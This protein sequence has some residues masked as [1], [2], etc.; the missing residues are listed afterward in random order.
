MGLFDV[1]FTEKAGSLVSVL[2]I[3]TAAR[4][5]VLE[6]VRAL[7]FDLRVQIVRVE[8]VVQETGL[9]ERFHIAEFDGA[10]IS[11]RRAAAIR[12]TVR[13]ALRARS[14]AEAAA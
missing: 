1:R 11:R 12:S 5:S 6:S 4:L 7:L 9:V 2:E 8:S 13:K 14:G 10:A 3:V